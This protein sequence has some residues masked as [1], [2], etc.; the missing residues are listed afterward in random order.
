MTLKD[1]LEYVNLLIV[2]V[3]VYVISIE[4]RITKIEVVQDL[5]T[6]KEKY[7]TVS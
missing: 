7:G 3:L 1:L 6:Q 5:K 4:K 2:P